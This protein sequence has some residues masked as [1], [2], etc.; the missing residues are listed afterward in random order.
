[1]SAPPKTVLTASPEE[2][3]AIRAALRTPDLSAF[4]G[5]AVVATPAH[6]PALT[7]LLADPAGSDPICDRPR[8][9]TL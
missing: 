2:A 6:A 9:I 4:G 8:P 3:A 1:M 5:L 7:D